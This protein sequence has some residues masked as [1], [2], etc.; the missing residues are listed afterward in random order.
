LQAK[1]ITKLREN[2]RKIIIKKVMNQE[3]NKR[4]LLV[5]NFLSNSGINRSV[6]EDLAIQLVNAGW[7]VVTTSN[8]RGRLSRLINMLYT[9][10]SQRHQYL[11]AQVDV[12]SGP[13]FIWAEAVCR[14]LDRVGKPYILTLHGGNLPIFSRRWPNRVRSLLRYATAVTT[15][16]RYLLEEMHYYRDDI[17][18]IPNALNQSAYH[19]ILRTRVKP[20][21]VWLRAFHETYNPSLAPEV[22]AKLT[23]DFPNVHLIMVGPD[24]GDGSFQKTQQVAVKLG[25]RDLITLPGGISKTEVPLWMNKGDI[26]LNTTNV[27]NTPVSV[28]EAMAC[29]LC[30]VS[31]NVGGI[32]YLLEHELDALLVSS[33]DPDNMAESVRRILTE[34]DLAA[35]L[36]HNARRKAEK[37]DWSIILPRWESLLINVIKQTNSKQ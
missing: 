32:P 9:T 11:I 30:V 29:G 10:W 24:K 17:R 27:D 13:A 2:I 14:L 35:R 18:L 31:T 19:F 21:L 23:K 12:Y 33:N 20:R 34:P 25:V 4:I 1:G 22:L 6:C 7:Y 36:S 8:R 5:G 15:P 26:F 3:L 28:L 16:S 37:F